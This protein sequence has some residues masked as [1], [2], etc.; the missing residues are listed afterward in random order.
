MDRET[1][2]QLA[3]E[4]INSEKSAAK[5]KRSHDSPRKRGGIGIGHF[6]VPVI[7]TSV[8]TW[9]ALLL[10]L[11]GLLSIAVGTGVGIASSHLIIKHVL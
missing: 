3:D 1:A 5:G 6:V 9:F 10:D 4:L 2:N 11:S 8:A 7:L